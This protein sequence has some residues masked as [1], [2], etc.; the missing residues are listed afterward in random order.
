MSDFEFD[1]TSFNVELTTSQSAFSNLAT[2]EPQP[3]PP[4][5]SQTAHSSTELINQLLQLQISQ[6][7]LLNVIREKQKTLMENPTH[8]LFDSVMNEEIK[9]E[10][11][12]ESA[13]QNLTGLI[14]QVQLSPGEL[15]RVDYLKNEFF[16]QYHQLRLYKIEIEQLKF[17]QRATTP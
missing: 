15:H 17:Q 4:P 14:Q 13:M 8:E 2:N 6:T 11:S 16:I 3:F 7:H 12:L 1:P 9:L 10:A 5:P